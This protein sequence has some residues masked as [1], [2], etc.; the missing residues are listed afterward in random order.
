MAAI[1]MS[2]RL[3]IDAIAV[4]EHATD[5][6]AVDDSDDADGSVQI[7][8]VRHPASDAVVTGMLEVAAQSAKRDDRLCLFGDNGFQEDWRAV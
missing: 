5:N 8:G 2:G 3:K 4:G 1:A 7:R 6:L